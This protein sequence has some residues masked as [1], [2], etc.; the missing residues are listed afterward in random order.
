[1]ACVDKRGTVADQRRV[2]R[3]GRR[4]TDVQPVESFYVETTRELSR[5]KTVVQALVDAVQALTGSQRKPQ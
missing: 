2:T 3:N 1:M 4:A 5:L